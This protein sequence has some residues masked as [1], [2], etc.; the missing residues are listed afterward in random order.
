MNLM[1]DSLFAYRA[2]RTPVR[3]LDILEFIESVPVIVVCQQCG[4][5]EAVLISVQLPLIPLK[6]LSSPRC[7]AIGVKDGMFVHLGCHK[8]N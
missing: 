1:L 7:C 4:Y 6:S 3:E 2:R 8:T 5:V